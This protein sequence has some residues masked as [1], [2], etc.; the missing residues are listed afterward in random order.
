MHCSLPSCCCCGWATFY[1][2]HQ[3]NSKVRSEDAPLCCLCLGMLI[4]VSCNSAQVENWGRYKSSWSTKKEPSFPLDTS[5]RKGEGSQTQ[6]VV[7]GAASRSSQKHSVMQGWDPAGTEKEQQEDC[8]VKGAGGRQ[9][10][11]QMGRGDR[12]SN[13]RRQQD[14]CNTK[15][16]NS[17]CCIKNKSL[18]S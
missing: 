8:M 18:F 16:T 1:L 14:Q 4:C 9:G 15:S 17:F 5:A 10:A 3:A 7:A 6:V 2:L 11:E 13:R 12:M